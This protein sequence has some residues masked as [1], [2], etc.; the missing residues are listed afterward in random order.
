MLRDSVERKRR[1]WLMITSA[2]RRRIE[3]ALQPFD[4]GQVEMVGRLV[5]QQDVGR[6]RQHARER[7][8][9]RLAA[10]EMRR[11]FAAGEAE[12]LQQIARGMRVVGRP[13]AGLDIGERRG[14][15]REVRLLRQI[16]HRRAGLHE[17]RAAVGLDQ[18]GRDLQQRRFARA[19][20]ADQGHALAGRDRQLR[21]RQQRRAAEG[22]R[23]V[24]E[25]KERSATPCH[26]AGS[27]H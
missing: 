2:A 25:L 14:E 1:S 9:A 18:P 19:V 7:G 22:Q 5:E 8:A 23:D 15:A 17:H 21:A 20:A 13:Q 16:A 4:G 12:L 27:G 24:F 26:V 3:L 6:R 10:G 11:V